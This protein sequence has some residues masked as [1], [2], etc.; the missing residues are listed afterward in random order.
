MSRICPLC[1][2]EL[3]DGAKF[4]TSCGN[5]VP[6]AAPEVQAEAPVQEAAP[7]YSEPAYSEPQTYAYVNDVAPEPKKGNGFAIASLVLGILAILCCIIDV[8]SMILGIAAIVFGI[9]ALAK[10]QSKGMAIAG[11]IC[12][13]LGFIIAIIL[14]AAAAAMAPEIE[15]MLADMMKE[16]GYNF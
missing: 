16:Y 3:A 14:I 15:E 10:K 4:C 1:G 11:I 12:G 7:V 13:A 5:A 8:L 9:I 2:A 6:E